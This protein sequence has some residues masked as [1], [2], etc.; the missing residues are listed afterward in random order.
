L[1]RIAAHI[2]PIALASDAPRTYLSPL[3]AGE[4]QRFAEFQLKILRGPKV[5][6]LG[7]DDE[8]TQRRDHANE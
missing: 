8:R 1:D 2:T 7:G 6:W 3:K 4:V 5:A